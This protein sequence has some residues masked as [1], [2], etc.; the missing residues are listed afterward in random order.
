MIEESEESE[1]E[2]DEE[3][4]QSGNGSEAELFAD[5]VSV[6]A[7]VDPELPRLTEVKETG[8]RDDFEE[9]LLGTK[10]GKQLDKIFS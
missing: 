2:K 3:Q 7:E 5:D 4:K 6:K 1:E 9:V 10:T 8:Q